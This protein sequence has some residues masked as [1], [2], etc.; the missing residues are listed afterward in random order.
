[1][2]NRNFFFISHKH[3]TSVIM[4]IQEQVYTSHGRSVCSTLFVSPSTQYLQFLSGLTINDGVVMKLF[5]SLPVIFIGIFEKDLS[6][7]TL[8]AVP[9]LYHRGQRGEGF[10]FKVYFWWMFLAS[11]QAMIT[12]FM[13]Y[14]LYASSI[15]VKDGGVFAMGVLTYSVVVT[16][17]SSKLQ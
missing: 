9:E 4:V 14:T 3:S 11:S 15:I 16:L 1:M 2:C 17:I 5:T 10:N 7:S 13:A 12:Y 6:A 8:L